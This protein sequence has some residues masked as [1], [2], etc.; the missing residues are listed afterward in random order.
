MNMKQTKLVLLLATCIFMVACG[1]DDDAPL[2][3][4][5]EIIGE[6]EDDEDDTF[7]EFTE[8][9]LTYTKD[10]EKFRFPYTFTAQNNN[11]NVSYS[12]V[13]YFYEKDEL[14]GPYAPDLTSSVPDAPKVSS[15]PGWTFVGRIEN[16]SIY[17]YAVKYKTS[18]TTPV[19]TTQYFGSF[20]N[21]KIVSIETNDAEETIMKLETARTS[22]DGSPRLATETYTLK[23]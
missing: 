2:S 3:F 10:G 5:Q 19:F 9:T 21:W 23:L 15:V 11:I 18:A 12:N 8:T 4:K 13:L 14:W 17:G 6:W 7:L 16:Y 1:G 20:S 22:E